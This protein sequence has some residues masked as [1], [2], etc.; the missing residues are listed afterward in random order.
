[1]RIHLLDGVFQPK[2]SDCRDFFRDIMGKE[3]NYTIHFLDIIEQLAKFDDKL[4]AK[5]ELYL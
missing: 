1:V 4:L 3:Y 2:I 5:N